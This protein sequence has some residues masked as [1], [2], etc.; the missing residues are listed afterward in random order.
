MK[1]D[2]VYKNQALY[3]SP[4][5]L[6]KKYG[7]DLIF[8]TAFK[9]RDR[10]NPDDFNLSFNDD[11]EPS[12]VREN[13]KKLLDL[14]EIKTTN[15]IIFLKQTHSSS[16]VIID[17]NFL[18]DF[19][20]LYKE[21]DKPDSVNADIC[22]SGRIKKFIPKGDALITAIPDIPIM[23]LGADCNII[24]ICD[25]DLKVI[26]AVHAGWRGVLHD[27]LGKTLDTM[28][29]KFDCR[30]KNLFLFFGPS[31]R[32]CCFET[33]HDIYMDFKARF[34]EVFCIDS[35]ILNG[36]RYFVDLTN[37]LRYQAV[38]KGIDD[39]NIC[40]IE[41]CTCCSRRNL[42][43]SYRR[44]KKAGRQAALAYIS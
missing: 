3:F 5:E 38:R 14:S 26:S 19:K 30:Q 32:K 24:L 39:K 6:Q 20:E 40:I 23:V 31:I 21:I 10:E 9:G 8:T 35:G 42:F 36:S 1:I 16:V 4:T 22:E 13:R 28:I 29:E 7:L 27:I 34:P 41:E 17:K 18:Y 37:I 33:D 15:P 25:T 2:E 11:Y 43:F 12:K 44:D